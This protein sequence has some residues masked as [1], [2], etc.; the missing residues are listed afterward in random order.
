MQLKSES[1]ERTLPENKIKMSEEMKWLGS[2]ECSPKFLL[3][4]SKEKAS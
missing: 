4:F 2:N 1:F 3:F